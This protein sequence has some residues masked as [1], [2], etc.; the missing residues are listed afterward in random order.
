MPLEEAEPK[1]DPTGAGRF[2]DPLNVL[3]A[4]SVRPDQ[5]PATGFVTEAEYRALAFAAHVAEDEGAPRRLLES[6]S[7][8]LFSEAELQQEHVEARWDA[9]LARAYLGTHVLSNESP[10]GESIDQAVGTGWFTSAQPLDSGLTA[11]VEQEPGGRSDLLQAH[12]FVGA[13]AG[14]TAGSAGSLLPPLWLSHRRPPMGGRG[15]AGSAGQPRGGEPGSCRSRTEPSTGAVSGRPHVSRFP[16]EFLPAAEV[17]GPA[18]ATCRD[19]TRLC[20]VASEI[21]LLRACTQED[22][23]LFVDAIEVLSAYQPNDWPEL[24]AEL[25]RLLGVPNEYRPPVEAIRVWIHDPRSGHRDRLKTMIKLATAYTEDEAVD[26]LRKHCAGTQRTQFS[27][28]RTVNTSCGCCVR[29]SPEGAIMSER[30][31]NTRT[32]GTSDLLDSYLDRRLFGEE[33]DLFGLPEYRGL[34]EH[35][36]GCLECRGRYVATIGMLR[37]EDVI[38]QCLA[39]LEERADL[40]AS[41]GVASAQVEE[42]HELAVSPSA[43]GLFPSVEVFRD[44][45]RA[46]YGKVAELTNGLIPTG[47]LPSFALGGVRGERAAGA[48]S[49]GSLEFFSE[50]V[51][52]AG[53]GFDPLF[54]VVADDS[55]VRFV[56]STAGGRTSEEVAPPMVA[57]RSASG[58]VVYAED[59]PFAEVQRWSSDGR[60][61]IVTAWQATSERLGERVRFDP[62]EWFFVYPQKPCP[63]CSGEGAVGTANG[64]RHKCTRCSGTGWVPNQ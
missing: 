37:D 1:G 5:L 61:V 21:L 11:F 19:V 59:L 54:K 17:G 63:E 27:P 47:P 50:A 8:A 26:R 46:A 31:A 60:R 48:V 39:H 64:S 14:R 62:L 23:G 12:R 42:E 10:L 40:L 38:E 34:L 58:G 18:R 43:G 3:L 51:E 6:F 44:W 45:V 49:S 52:L 30:T 9:V 55:S 13:L 32:C 57:L 16:E 2:P 25:I 53:R 22:H 7:F 20:R 29:S 56:F 36:A 28:R 15:H 41:L 33:G 4:H 24:R 35:L